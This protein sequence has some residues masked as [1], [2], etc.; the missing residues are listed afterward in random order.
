MISD[1][2][3][4]GFVMNARGFGGVLGLLLAAGLAARVAYVVAQ[5]ASDP[6]FARPVLDGAYHL[7]LARAESEGGAGPGGAYYL[8]P[9]YA[10]FLAAVVGPA[11]EVDFALLYILQH[12]MVVAAAG[13][14]AIVGRRR[15]GSGAGLGAATLL[16]LYRPMLF[17]ASAPL[18]EALAILLL[19]VALVL[20]CDERRWTP[21]A[22]GIVSGV[23][24]IVRPNLLLVPL[25]WAGIDLGTRRIARGT[26]VLLGLAAVLLPVAAR[27]ARVSGHAVPISANAG[28]TLFHGN[29]PGAEGGYTRPPGFSGSLAGQREEAT[30]IASSRAGRELDDV[31]ADRFWGAAALKTR[32]AE[33]LDTVVL[34][35][36]K[37][38]LSLSSTELALDYAP[39]LDANPWR[40]V[41]P[42]PLGVILGLAVAGAIVLGFRGSGGAVTWSAILACGA[43]LGIFYVSSRYRL[44]AA[45]LLCVPAGGGAAVLLSR[46]PRPRRL[47]AWTAAV[48]VALGSMLL[49]TFGIVD[50]TEAE[51]LSNRAVARV[52]AEDRAGAEKD[53]REALRRDPTSVAAWFNLGTFLAESGETRAA[54]DAYR[55]AL[56]HD[57]SHVES[58]GNLAFLMLR[59]GR[60]ADALPILERAIAARPHDSACWNNLVAARVMLGDLEGARAAVER[61]TGL[62]VT[63]DPGLLEVVGSHGE[64]PPPRP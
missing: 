8:A 58:A 61:A 24:S 33:P 53:L 52:A 26:A 50:R 40:W 34:L 47:A 32:L 63:L 42:L 57:P 45:A 49:P 12:A 20:C 11:G 6:S 51:A 3:A 21:A 19:S 39:A 64:S 4:M 10:F 16:L 28:I 41:A 17:F 25:A 54:E 27:N 36:K 2:P 35:F 18:S 29:G 43:S 13:L 60:A 14:L 38:V 22:A 59:V 44:P 62:N 30:R 5:P 55:E 9:G 37:G 1:R 31:E 23:A 48:A 7:A 15:I 56:R 46:G